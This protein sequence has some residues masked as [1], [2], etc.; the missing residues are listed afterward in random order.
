MHKPAVKL[1]RQHAS[2]EQEYTHM[3]RCM[4]IWFWISI[5]NPKVVGEDG[6]LVSGQDSSQMTGA[7]TSDDAADKQSRWRWGL[8]A[9][10]GNVQQTLN[11]PTTP[12]LHLAAARFHSLRL[13]WMDL[14]VGKVTEE[15]ERR[16]KVNRL[17]RVRDSWRVF[18][19]CSGPMGRLTFGLNLASK[20]NLWP[21]TQD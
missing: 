7:F 19:S 13:S 4:A 2:E 18:P 20:Q 12:S 9:A 16:N 17:E 15:W 8:G 11:S 10:A 6:N 5:S 14:N 3:W 1:K 21:L